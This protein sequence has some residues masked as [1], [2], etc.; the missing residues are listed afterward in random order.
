MSPLASRQAG[1]R[2]ERQTKAALEARGW[3][4]IR[5]GGSLGVADLVGLRAGQRPILVAC[6]TSG[7]LPKSERTTLLEV[8][9]RCDAQPVLAQRPV[10]A[11]G[12]L[13]GGKVQ[14]FTVLTN[15]VNFELDVLPIPRRAKRDD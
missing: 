6:K 10:K 11:N 3:W 7:K 4:V 15:G 2:F 1:D 14:T 13:E 9:D 5:S 8:A 12:L